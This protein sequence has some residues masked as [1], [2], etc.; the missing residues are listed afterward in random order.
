MQDAG[1]DT[2]PSASSS[3]SPAAGPSTPRPISTLPGTSTTPATTHLSEALSLPAAP[4][5]IGQPSSSTA[6]SGFPFI[7]TAAWERL[8]PPAALPVPH[9]V[10][11]ADVNS[12]GTLLMANGGRSKY[13]GPN[14]SSEWLR[15]VCWDGGRC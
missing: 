15:D 12:S 3:S 14:A 4:S 1:S 13:L 8:E 10:S 7:D 2:M 11:A 9:Q 5:S 6:E